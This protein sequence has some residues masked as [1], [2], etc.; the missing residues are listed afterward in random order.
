MQNDSGVLVGLNVLDEACVL[1]KVYEMADGVSLQLLRV[2]VGLVVHHGE[3]I[4]PI[5]DS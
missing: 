4:L 1:S 2:H 5:Q 3:E